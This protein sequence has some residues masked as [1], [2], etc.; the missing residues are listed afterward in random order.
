[1]LPHRTPSSLCPG[2]EHFV[3]FSQNSVAVAPLFREPPRPTSSADL[4]SVL[5]FK[6]SRNVCLHIASWAHMKKRPK[7]FF[8]MCPGEDLNLHPRK[9]IHL[10]DACIPISPP[11][12][13]MGTIPTL[14]HLDK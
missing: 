13:V 2:E 1:M 6:S 5:A 3:S 12:P 7:A 4:V 9:D 14:S 11:G 8:H 10:K